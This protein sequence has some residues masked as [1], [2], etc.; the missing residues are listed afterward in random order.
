M[1]AT[2]DALAVTVPDIGDFG[3][4]PVIEILVAVGDTVA[5]EDPLV[6]LESDK[7]TM[8]VPSPA[9]GT[10]KAIHVK[11]GDNV[12][13]GSLVLDLETGA[14]QASAPAPTPSAEQTPA[15]T[16]ELVEPKA[17]ESPVAQATRIAAEADDASATPAAPATHVRAGERQR[18]RPCVRKSVGPSDCARAR[19]RS[20]WRGGQWS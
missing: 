18:R 19:H 4:V 13:E 17:S 11:V 9:A 14:A 20:A 12:S 1:S 15:P 16:P 2:A 5:A 8:D 10:V 3:D 7:A 6:T